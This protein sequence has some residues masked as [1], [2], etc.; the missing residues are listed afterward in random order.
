M[1]KF[2][3]GQVWFY[4]EPKNCVAK[5]NTED[6]VQ[7]GSRPVIIVSNNTGN[8][9]SPVITVVPCTTQQKSNI[10]TH[11]NFLLDATANTVLCE[12]IFTVGKADLMTYRGTLDDAEVSMLNRCLAAA[13]LLN[14]PQV[15]VAAPTQEHK[16]TNILTDKLP[17]EVTTHS[18]QAQQN[19]TKHTYI[20]RTDKEKQEII[21]AY[22]STA[23]KDEL[24]ELARRYNFTN[25]KMLIQ[26]VD[27]WMRNDK[28]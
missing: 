2:L 19:S 17:N 23:R 21:T 9:N 4:S 12:Q 6:S 24:E 5:H 11:F 27:R 1:Q 20:K 8:K 13:L 28:I 15:I 25:S 26:S 14:E 18:E 10:P 16:L 3:R 7:R 22:C